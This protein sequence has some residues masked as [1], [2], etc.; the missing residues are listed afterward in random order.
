VVD[1]VVA[2]ERGVEDRHLAQGR[3]D[4]SD[5]ERVDRQLYLVALAQ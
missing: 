3:H 5:H 1:E 4:G 2:V